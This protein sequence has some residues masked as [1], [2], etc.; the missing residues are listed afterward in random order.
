LKK[1]YSKDPEA[2]GFGI[3][4]VFWFGED[5]G[6]RLPEPPAGVVRPGT[7]AEMEAA[8]RAL[9]SGEDWQDTE[10]VCIDCSPRKVATRRK[11]QG[12]KRARKSGGRSR[13]Q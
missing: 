1:K 11:S 3:Y 4:L 13:V 2:K 9:Y 8:L 6:R 10:F 12:K 5:N 7:A